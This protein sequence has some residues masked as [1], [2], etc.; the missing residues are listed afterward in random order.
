MGMAT[1]RYTQRD[2]RWTDIKILEGMVSCSKLDRM[3]MGRGGERPYILC[4]L[5]RSQGP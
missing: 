5:P 1:S 4:T 2:T 3:D